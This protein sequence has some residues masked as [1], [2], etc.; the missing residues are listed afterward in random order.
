MEK[1]IETVF[2]SW[3]VKG[4]AIGVSVVEYW[5]PA[6]RLQG[7]WIASMNY[8]LKKPDRGCRRMMKKWKNV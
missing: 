1:L 7:C 5:I 2:E 4:R 6:R 3:Y 8:I